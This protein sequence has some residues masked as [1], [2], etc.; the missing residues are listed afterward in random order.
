MSVLVRERRFYRSFFSLTGMIAV[1]NLLTFSVNLADNLMLGAY[2]ETALAGSALVNQIQFLLQM[3]VM[4]VG[5]GIVVLASQYWGKRDVSS[6]R[7]VQNIGMRIA[8]GAAL[9]LWALVF[10]F[11]RGCLGLLTNEQPVIEEAAKYLQ[12]I[13][14]SYV[15]F[16]MTNILLATLR[17]VET[18]KI[19][20]AVSGSTLLINCCLNTL[21]IF[22]TFGAPRLGIRGAA[23]ATLVSRIVE[24][25]IMVLYTAFSDKKL[26]ARL[27]DFGRMDGLLFRD[28][29]RVGLPV[30]LS[31]TMWGLAQAIQTSIL[32]H[33][34]QA[35]IAANSI[36]T[37]IFQIISVVTYGAASASS[38][39]VGKT[40]GENRLDDVKAYAKTLQVLYLGIGVGTG[41]LLF[42]A[43]DFIL[44]F[45]SIAADTRALASLFITV[46]S[47]TVV[48]TSYQVA[49]LTGIVRG[50]GDTSFVL[51]NDFIFMWLIVL[52]SAALAAFV[53]HLPPPVVFICLKSDQILKCFVAVVQ[54]NFFPWIRRL[55]RT[56]EE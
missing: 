9:V 32:G 21:L 23:I 8:V 1:Q 55:T 7:R 24:F 6:I 40:I 33:M 3:V 30:I 41:L 13:C 4:G 19:S 44:G 49:V 37:T 25:L 14:F 31:N 16:A 46:L 28:Y 48:G 43:K 12:I 11:P 56:T 27:K 18:V 52:P 54:V 26:H 10:F 39:I 15:F 53:F 36:A 45:Y 35:T 22:G 42:L 2:S 34:G 50:A 20:F 29:L 5:E 17:S 51:V 38:V 47:V